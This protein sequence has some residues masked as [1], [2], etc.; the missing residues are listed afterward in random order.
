MEV[1]LKTNSDLIRLVNICRPPYG[2]K[3][4]YTEKDFLPEFDEYLSILSNKPG[5][6][7]IMGDF[8]IPMQ[9]IETHM[10]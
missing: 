8:N 7:V 6:I 2:I 10:T 9:K 5:E 4:C 3:H 1:T